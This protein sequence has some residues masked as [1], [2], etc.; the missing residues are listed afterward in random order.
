MTKIFIREKTKSDYLGIVSSTLCALHCAFTP[1][2]IAALSAVKTAEN[3]FAWLDYV[4]VALCLWAVYHAS[5]HSSSKLIK[6][7]LWAAWA[8]FAIGIVFEDAAEGM[9]YMGYAGS[10]G[11][12]VL[13]IFNIRYFMHCEKCAH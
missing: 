4:F 13:H 3:S 7:G 12:V 6:M 2:F 9:V 8:V 10:L 5:K 11:L 1:F